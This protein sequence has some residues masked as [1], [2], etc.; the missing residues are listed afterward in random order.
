MQKSLSAKHSP[1][2]QMAAHLEAITESFAAAGVDDWTIRSRHGLVNVRAKT[3]DGQ[4]VTFSNQVSSVLQYQ[5]QS[6]CAVL[7]IRQRRLEA[8]RLRKRGLTQGEIADM[9]GVSQKTI[10][11]DLSA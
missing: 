7:T 1:F 6:R 5:T 10:S 9:L 8:K 2:K 3:P 4:A 11:N